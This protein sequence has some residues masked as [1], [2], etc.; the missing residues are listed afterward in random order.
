MARLNDTRALT[1]APSRAGQEHHIRTE[2][3]DNGY[4]VHQHVCTD[5]GE[6]KS[7]TRFMDT[8]PR[9]VPGRVAGSRNGGGSDAAGSRGLG[10]AV[11]YAGKK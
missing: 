9:V 3:I 1:D 7:S 5:T 6:F 10:D 8:P 4:L 11:Q 2:K